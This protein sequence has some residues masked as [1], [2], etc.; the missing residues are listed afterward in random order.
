MCLLLLQTVHILKLGLIC[1]VPGLVRGKWCSWWY[2]SQVGE[3]SWWHCDTAWPLR[4]WLQSISPGVTLREGWQRCINSWVLGR[5][6]APASWLVALGLSSAPCPSPALLGN[7]QITW[8]LFF[9]KRLLEKIT[10]KCNS[11]SESVKLVVLPVFREK[12]WN[13]TCEYCTDWT[14]R[15][16]SL[17]SSL[18]CRIWGVSVRLPTSKHS[19]Q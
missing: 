19:T 5:G 6:W 7:L 13:V 11:F 10:W 17:F 8:G 16:C 2:L 14:Q 4:A 3:G 12:H 1:P 9:T 15:P 18:F